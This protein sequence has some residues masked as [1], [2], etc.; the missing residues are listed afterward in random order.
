MRLTW[1]YR[2]WYRGPMKF[3]DRALLKVYLEAED[4]ARLSGQAQGVGKP[5]AEYARE[6]VLEH[7]NAGREGENLRGDSELP[8][9]Q[10]S[11]P[12]AGRSV[13]A[14]QPP[15]VPKP[16]AV[17]RPKTEPAGPLFAKHP[18]AGIFNAADD[19][20]EPQYKSHSPECSCFLCESAIKAG[21]KDD[22]R[23]KKEE[24]KPAKRGRR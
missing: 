8:A 10:G 14:H 17:P 7:L 23:A 20:S 19:L 18:G 21:L 5:A 9:V 13:P 3:R 2:T 1:S 22:K 11:A 12:D 15:A 24:K 6:L 4:L 16:I